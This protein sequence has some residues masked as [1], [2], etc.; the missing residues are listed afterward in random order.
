MKKNILAL[1]LFCLFVISFIL[2]PD[3]DN[4]AELD[5]YGKA[6]ILI[7]ALS[8]LTLWVWMINNAIKKS[9]TVWVWLMII[10]IVPAT[11]LYLFFIF[12]QRPLEN[13]Q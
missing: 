3:N 13:Q 10:T 7:G 9:K 1:S 5:V 11:A 2:L 6:T 4:G 12:I 8:M